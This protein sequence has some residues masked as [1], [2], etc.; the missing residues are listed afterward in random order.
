MHLTNFKVKA[1]QSYSNDLVIRII[2]QGSIS[3]ITLISLV[4]TKLPPRSVLGMPIFH[5]ARLLATRYWIAS[6]IFIGDLG[7]AFT[8]ECV[9][10]I[11]V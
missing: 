3:Q 1:L 4:D 2:W 5:K 9:V 11:A 8:N 7:F 10:E 6:E